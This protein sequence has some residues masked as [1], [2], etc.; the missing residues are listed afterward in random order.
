MIKHQNY[1][2]LQLG[3]GKYT[4]VFCMELDSGKKVA[5]KV[6]K[7]AYEKNKFFQDQ[8]IREAKL[9]MQLRHP[10]VRKVLDLIH[11]DVEGTYQVMME[12]VDGY[13]MK[14]YI[15]NF[16]T[17][18]EKQVVEW[19]MNILPGLNQAHRAGIVHGLLKPGNFIINPMG[20][21][22]IC[23]FKGGYF[24]SELFPEDVDTQDILYLSP[25]QIQH[26]GSVTGQ[27]D[28][29]SLGVT[30][31]TLLSG[32]LPYDAD[33]ADVNEVRLRIL[34]QPLP[35]IDHVSVQLNSIIQAA[36]SKNPMER[37]S[38]A[39]RLMQEL[40]GD[41]SAKFSTVFTKAQKIFDDEQ[42]ILT[43]E[44]NHPDTSSDP[45]VESL[46]VG[47]DKPKADDETIKEEIIGAVSDSID[48]D[49]LPNDVS[50]QVDSP[51]VQIIGTDGDTTAPVSSDRE[52]S[53]VTNA[54][55][56]VSSKDLD[57]RVNA[58][59]A[60]IGVSGDNTE[61]VVDKVPVIQLKDYEERETAKAKEK[62]EKE[63]K[64][65]D[66]IKSGTVKKL[67]VRTV[68]PDG[69][70][71]EPPQVVR[72][73]MENPV[74]EDNTIESSAATAT[75]ITP[76]KI[77]L[78]EEKA[79][80][81]KRLEE[82][83]GQ[84][85][86]AGQTSGYIKIFLGTILALGIV[87]VGAYVLYNRSAG[88]SVKIVTQVE[89][90]SSPDNQA[91]LPVATTPEVSQAEQA[92]VDSVIQADQSQSL[93]ELEKAKLEKLKEMAAL[94]KKQEEEAKKKE[95]AKNVDK[96]NI[97][98][99]GPYFNEIAPF[100]QND[101]IGFIDKDGKVI[102]KPVY[103]EILSFSNGL[104][105]VRLNSKWGFVNSL[106]KEVIKPKYNEIFGFSKGLA[107]VKKDNKWGFINTS[108][109]VVVPFQYDVVTDF[110]G[111]MAGVRKNGK[112]GFVSKN[113]MEAITCQ[114]DNAWSF[115]DGL[116]GVE[117]NNKWGFIN[118][119]GDIAIPLEY[120]QVN[121]FSEGFACVEKNGK[122]G[123]INKAGKEIISCKYEAAKPFKGGTA[124][125]FD[126]GKWV[127]INKS[128]KCVRDCN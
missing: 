112:W 18:P 40:E 92:V 123:Y 125:V 113:G 19:L 12:Y 3:Q 119:K 14:D 80:V 127:Y 67:A 101:L 81:E 38:G 23:D 45:V 78:H 51:D 111:G 28:I 75:A 7:P 106:G 24:E 93:E 26:M 50:T 120:G 63:K 30:L 128:G 21:L 53:G 11:D 91:N 54:D 103:E 44:E 33:F 29:Y 86:V 100:K 59:W 94:K 122:F 107:G 65:D 104:A 34:N 41:L 77:K 66:Q 32:R 37:Y 9:G 117:K 87:A 102:K 48:S 5:I 95:E 108:G 70:L 49:H 118:S 71:A 115:N 73:A 114:Y 110:A 36:T 84:K 8:L 35:F 31:Y 69:P 17:I 64:K 105:P 46:V 79:T 6:L 4:R 25:E 39:E 89:E 61:P 109:A 76:V 82:P 20:K 52:L 96:A 22:K 13:N 57:D 99:L 85:L 47:G 16:G 55:T 60:R 56:D 88:D 2:I 124:R 42:T 116:A 72:K 15:E 126:N 27:S 62:K 68:T 121:N 97:E 90:N 74:T 43:G 58:I 1:N 98:L 83:T 10:S